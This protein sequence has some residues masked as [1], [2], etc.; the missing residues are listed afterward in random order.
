MRIADMSIRLRTTT[1]Y[2]LVLTPPRPSRNDP[3]WQNH[4]QSPAENSAM[5]CAANCPTSEDPRARGVRVAVQFVYLPASIGTIV[6]N[7][8]RR[9]GAGVTS[10]RLV[11]WRSSNPS[12]C[13]LRHGTEER[14]P[15]FQSHLQRSRRPR[16]GS[17]GSRASSGKHAYL[18]S[19]QQGFLTFLQ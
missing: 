16:R 11:N 18:P 4:P 14:R 15:H 12:L 9:R 17:D 5:R 3:H 10:P 19:F 6:A 8:K 7:L 2:Q 1:P 13:W